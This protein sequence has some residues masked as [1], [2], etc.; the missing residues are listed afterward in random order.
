MHRRK[1]EAELASN[2]P[3]A[4]LLFVWPERRLLCN[5]RIESSSVELEREMEKEISNEAGDGES[6]GGKGGR[7]NETY[8]MRSELRELGDSCERRTARR[9]RNRGRGEVCEK[10]EEGVYVRT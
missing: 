10:S 1:E 6:R 8:E 2:R 5:E 3:F 9:V 7:V 4:S